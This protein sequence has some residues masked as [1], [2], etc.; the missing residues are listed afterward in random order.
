MINDLG[1][2]EYQLDQLQ[3]SKL[4]IPHVFKNMSGEIK[5]RVYD[6]HG[7]EFSDPAKIIV[8][9]KYIRSCMSILL[10]TASFRIAEKRKYYYYY[11][12]DYYDPS[13][14]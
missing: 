8:F 7:A 3:G 6:D 9:S 2:N 12:Y 11:Y 5:C 14:N 10:R 4:I 1:A 13:S